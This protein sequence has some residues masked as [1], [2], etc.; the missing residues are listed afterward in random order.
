MGTFEILT[1][2]LPL[3]EGDRYGTWSPI[4]KD[5]AGETE[6]FIMPFVNYSETVNAFIKDVYHFAETRPEM[7]LH[8]HNRILK[9]HNIDLNVDWQAMDIST[10]DAQ[11]IT[12]LIMAA[13][14]TERFCDG[15]LLGLLEGRHIQSWLDQLRRFEQQ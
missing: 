8:Q 13:V 14:R 1:K 15:T 7:E 10:Q 12:A 11:C 6:T 2:Y 9:D 3:L 5:R 4:H